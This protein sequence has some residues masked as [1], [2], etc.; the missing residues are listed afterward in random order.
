MSVPAGF[1]EL[2]H[3]A[4]RLSV[5]SLLAA[6]E[7]AEFSFV[8]DSLSLSDSALSKQLHTL[9]EAGYL[10]LR[11]EGGGRNRRTRVRLTDRGR[12][13]FEGHVSALRAI[14]EGA[15]PAVRTPSGAKR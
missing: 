5:V 14:V 9:E 4:T 6:T 8:R 7:W 10:E 13:A 12:T 1:D 3:P 2:I 15:A 11:K